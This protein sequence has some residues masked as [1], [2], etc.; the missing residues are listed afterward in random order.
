MHHCVSMSYV[1]EMFINYKMVSFQFSNVAGDAKNANVPPPTQL[2]KIKVTG[3]LYPKK[4]KRQTSSRFNISKNR[5][6]QKL[7][8]L[9]GFIF[10]C[11]LFI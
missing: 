5:E 8:L 3:V 4:D 6:L 11:I 2:T 1:N 7:P 10:F 9:K